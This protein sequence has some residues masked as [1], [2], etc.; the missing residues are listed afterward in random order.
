MYMKNEKIVFSRMVIH[1][2]VSVMTRFNETYSF[3]VKE[4][5][6]CFKYVQLF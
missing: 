2:S 4:T 6:I 3:D 1:V 5:K